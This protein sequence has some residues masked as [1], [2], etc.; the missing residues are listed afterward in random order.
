MAA[1][2]GDDGGAKAEA[3]GDEDLGADGAVQRALEETG[4]ELGE[5][6]FRGDLGEMRVHRE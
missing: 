3:A 6:L 4:G 5:E 1:G 2:V